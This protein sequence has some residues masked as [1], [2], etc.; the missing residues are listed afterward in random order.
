MAG[1][2]GV[3]TDKKAIANDWG[4]ATVNITQVGT[5]DKA[6]YQYLLTPLELV[7][8]TVKAGAGVGKV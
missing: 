3:F 1:A 2:K 7:E 5:F 8:E 4:T 6:P